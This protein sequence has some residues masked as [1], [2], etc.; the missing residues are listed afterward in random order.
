LPALD[1]ETLSCEE[2]YLLQPFSVNTLAVKTKNKKLNL[3][4][5]DGRSDSLLKRNEEFS[6]QIVNFFYSDTVYL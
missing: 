3:R 6:D 4:T 1:E 2:A 5:T